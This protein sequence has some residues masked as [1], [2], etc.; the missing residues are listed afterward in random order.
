MTRDYGGLT[1]S[2]IGAPEHFP[3][4]RLRRAVEGRGG[5]LAS[6]IETKSD[7]VVIAHGAVGR[8]STGR[9]RSV[10]GQA[11]SDLLTEHQFLR[12]L[13]LMQ[14][15]EPK[16]HDYDMAAFSEQCRLT[17]REVATLELFDVLEPDEG[18]YAFRDLVLAR[19]IR[20]LLD[21][22]VTL[23]IIIGAS[24]AFRRA[25]MR[26]AAARLEAAR[27]VSSREL[28]VPMDTWLRTIEGRNTPRRPWQ[29]M[30]LAA[31]FYDLAEAAERAE[32]WA[33]AEQL[34]QRCARIDAND[35][36]A[37]FHQARMVRRQK[38]P[39]EAATVFRDATDIDPLLAD[40]WFALG[41]LAHERGDSDQART[42]F[43][44]SL[45]CDPGYADAAFHLAVTH[46][47]RG[48]V[49]SALPLFE[50]YAE[51]DP[52]GRWRRAAFRA[53]K[54]CRVRA[55]NEPARAKAAVS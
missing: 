26:N 6:R 41:E 23:P 17:R 40:A 44:A 13:G 19:Q 12:D 3:A 4:A 45:A 22:G 10:L 34:Y 43:A 5:T 9:L 54:L 30:P 24:V 7:V 20:S 31:Y 2:L 50:R 49:R 37:R 38:R 18:H 33:L 29:D 32:G 52:D 21:A 51:H 27:S 14:P 47:D 16:V 8:L 39:G 25:A 46:L 42:H 28:V 55:P 53:A 1:V 36:L 48:D 35:A 15:L 11:G